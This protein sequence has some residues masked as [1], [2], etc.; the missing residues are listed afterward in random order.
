[1]YFA[2]LEPG[3]TFMSVVLSLNHPAGERMLTISLG[4]N[5]FKAIGVA[6]VLWVMSELLIEG[7]RLQTENQQFV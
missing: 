3:D 5:E 7:C 6:L 2:L 4:S 1:M